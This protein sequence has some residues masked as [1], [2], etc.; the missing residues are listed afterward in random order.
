MIEIE[1]K[2]IYITEAAG[3]LFTGSLFFLYW[4]KINVAGEN[5]YGRYYCN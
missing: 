5:D 2:F 3:K 1:A 4:G